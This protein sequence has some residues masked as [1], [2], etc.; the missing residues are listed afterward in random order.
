MTKRKK[1]QDKKADKSKEVTQKLN[2]IIVKKEKNKSKHVF[3]VKELIE[4]L[5]KDT[6]VNYRKDDFV[7]LFEGN[8][9]LRNITYGIQILE[10]K[11]GAPGKVIQRIETQTDFDNAVA[12]IKE[13]VLS[14]V[15]R[16][17]K[18]LSDNDEVKIALKHKTRELLRSAKKEGESW[19]SL[20]TRLLEK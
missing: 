5:P 9:Y 12:Q 18:K 13:N 16:E 14:H 4:A 1:P 6:R 3:R 10:N 17:Y 19:D 2:E 11:M 8:V 15:P 7:K 20:I